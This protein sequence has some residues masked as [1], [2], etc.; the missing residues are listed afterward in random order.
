MRLAGEFVDVKQLQHSV[1][2]AM[3][4]PREAGQVNM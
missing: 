3:R 4:R 1:D 2:N